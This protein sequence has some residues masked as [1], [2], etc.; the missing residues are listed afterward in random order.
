MAGAQHDRVDIQDGVGAVIFQVVFQLGDLLFI[1]RL[2]CLPDSLRGLGGVVDRHIQVQPVVVD[3][4]VGNATDLLYT[5]CCHGNTVH[6]SGGAV[7]AQP[8]R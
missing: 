6:P 1:S 3:L 4:R 8:L 7:Q 5:G 2:L